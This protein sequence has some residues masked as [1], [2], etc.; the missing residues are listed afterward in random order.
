MLT[1][2]EWKILSEE[3][4]SVYLFFQVERF[5]LRW[6]I[7]FISGRTFCTVKLVCMCGTVFLAVIGLWPALC[8]WIDWADHHQRTK[9]LGNVQHRTLFCILVHCK[10][11]Q[12]VP[13]MGPVYDAKKKVLTSTCSAGKWKISQCL[14]NDNNSRSGSLPYIW[15]VIWYFKF[16]HW[17]LR[18]NSSPNL[19]SQID[20]IA[21]TCLFLAS[22]L[23]ENDLSC[24]SGTK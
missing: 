24:Q 16:Y 18:G 21:S 6:S 19:Y 4:L 17:N 5:Q 12:A 11:P 3:Y 10:S 20:V 23:N 9:M 14:S 1:A 22:S 2:L 8:G 13:A 7:V 15:S